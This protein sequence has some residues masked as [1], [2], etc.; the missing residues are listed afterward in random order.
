VMVPFAPEW[1]YGCEGPSMPWY[2][3][4]RLVR[5]PQPDD[6]DSVLRA[7]GAELDALP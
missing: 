2:G 7:I 4:V 3:S 6:W 5:Q 1:R